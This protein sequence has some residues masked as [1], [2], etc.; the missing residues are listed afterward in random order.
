MLTKD[1]R[2][3]FAADE[4]YATRS[5]DDANRAAARVRGAQAAEA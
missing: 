1:V 5:G 2:G 4:V 3:Y